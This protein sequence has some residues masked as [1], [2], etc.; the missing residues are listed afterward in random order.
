MFD[1][2]MHKNTR[3][4]L[5]LCKNIQDEY[6]YIRQFI[7]KTAS[8]QS[9]VL[10]ESKCDLHVPLHLYQALHKYIILF[11]QCSMNNLLSA[12]E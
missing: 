1:R 2:N 4:L 10:E 5:V 6:M 3:D 7:N 9:F 11:L 12:L 8:Y